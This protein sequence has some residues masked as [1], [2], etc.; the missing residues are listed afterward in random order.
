MGS[1][2]LPSRFLAR[3]GLKPDIATERASSLSLS[4]SVSWK[5][6]LG[7]GEDPRASYPIRPLSESVREPRNAAV[8]NPTLVIVTGPTVA[9]RNGLGDSNKRPENR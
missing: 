6:R 3:K 7:G 9:T 5:R 1:F 2:D 8:A 4:L